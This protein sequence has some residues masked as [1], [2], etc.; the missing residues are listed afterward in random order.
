MKENE[1]IDKYLD[2][3]RELKKPGIIKKKV[4]L[5]IVAVQKTFSKVL[6]ERLGESE[7]KGKI[8]TMLSKTQFTAVNIKNKNVDTGIPESSLGTYCEI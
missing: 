7:I 3:A 4:L 5:N 8:K 1:K 6:G 2:P